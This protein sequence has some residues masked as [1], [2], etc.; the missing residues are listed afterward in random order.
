MLDRDIYSNFDPT[1]CDNSS[2]LGVQIM[3]PNGQGGYK[4]EN[5]SVWSSEFKNKTMTGKTIS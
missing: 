2:I 5:T 1:S 3:R 4:M